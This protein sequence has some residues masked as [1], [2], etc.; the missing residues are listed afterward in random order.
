MTRHR[1]A[2]VG[3]GGRLRDLWAAAEELLADLR[4]DETGSVIGRD[5]DPE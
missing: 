2:I 1:C 3:T 4:A 5:A